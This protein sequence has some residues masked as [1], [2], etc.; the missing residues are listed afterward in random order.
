[1][2]RH[3]PYAR[4]GRRSGRVGLAVW[5]PTRRLGRAAWHRAEDETGL[6]Q[7]QCAGPT[8]EPT[9]TLSWRLASRTPA[10]AARPPARDCDCALQTTETRADLLAMNGID[11]AADAKL[12]EPDRRC[13]DDEQRCD[14]EGPAA[15]RHHAPQRRGCPSDTRPG[16]HARP[17]GGR[18]ETNTGS[19]DPKKVPVATY[20]GTNHSSGKATA[21][22]TRTVRPP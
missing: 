19:L 16:E 22:V 14:A 8:R 9:G 21:N 5:S 3:A 12:G 4:A 11:C 20:G 2:M 7:Q 6:A 15:R 17:C 13:C 1:M 10:A 18:R